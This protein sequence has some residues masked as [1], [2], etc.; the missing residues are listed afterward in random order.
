MIY[1]PTTTQFVS[2][3]GKHS[4]NSLGK[5]LGLNDVL[6][7]ANRIKA[8]STSDMLKGAQ[9]I[10]NTELL[11]TIGIKTVTGVLIKMIDNGLNSLSNKGKEKVPL[12]ST[13]NKTPM[14]KCTATYRKTN[15]HLGK[16]TSKRLLRMQNQ[17]NIDKGYKLLASSD[18][19]YQHHN[20]RKSLMLESGFNEK[21][22]SF[23][24]EDTFL[25]VN[26]L[27]DLYCYCSEERV[28]II[29]SLTDSNVRTDLYGCMY[30]TVNNFKFMITKENTCMPLVGKHIESISKLECLV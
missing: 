23:F 3:V 22:F 15:V 13:D 17:P 7:H 1:K 29:Q 19:D 10:V 9:G 6:K 24:M 25:R 18:R 8:G 16:K 21:G 4:L 27:L 30:E 14:G 2:S 12:L 28:N 5:D 20:R 26:D 11:T